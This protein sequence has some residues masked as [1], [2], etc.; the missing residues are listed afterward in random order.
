MMIFIIVLLTVVAN[1]ESSV[2]IKF[3]KVENCTTTNKTLH[4]ERCDAC[5]GT[6]NVILEVFK[7]V[8]QMFVCKLEVFAYKKVL[9]FLVTLS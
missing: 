7:P 9:R 6:L 3:L 8:A 2:I 5:N 4:I 1:S